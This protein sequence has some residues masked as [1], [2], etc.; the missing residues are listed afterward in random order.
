MHAKTSHH[1]DTRPHLLLLLDVMRRKWLPLGWLTWLFFFSLNFYFVACFKFLCEKLNAFFC[2]I[3]L[4]CLS[5]SF[6]H[7]HH[8]RFNTPGLLFF[9][10]CITICAP[11]NIL[12]LSTS[13]SNVHVDP[14]TVFA[15]NTFIPKEKCYYFCNV[16]SVTLS[17]YIYS[18]FLLFI[19]VTEIACF[20]FNM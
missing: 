8:I 16:H 6:M 5:D 7:H 9:F 20:H 13:A 12:S 18:C 10:V 14:K 2:N 1:L 3:F 17:I 15:L 4:H 11:S 19:C